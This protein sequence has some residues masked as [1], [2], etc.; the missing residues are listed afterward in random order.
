MFCDKK[1]FLKLTQN[2]QKILV[3]ESP[4]T[5]KGFQT[6]RLATLLKRDIHTGVLEPAV[7]GFSSK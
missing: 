3:L 6:I 7:R 1:A 4:N 2:S 5:V